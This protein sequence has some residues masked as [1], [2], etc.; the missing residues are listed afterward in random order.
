MS[1]SL[2]IPED[3][4]KTWVE[5]LGPRTDLRGAS[6]IAKEME[7]ALAKA[8][9]GYVVIGRHQLFTWGENLQGIAR[10]AP[11]GSP[12]QTV[13]DEIRSILSGREASPSAPAARPAGPPPPP[14]SRDWRPTPPPASL[15]APPPVTYA[16][17]A[18]PAGASGG[19][20]VRLVTETAQVVGNVLREARREL[21]V[22]SPWTLGLETLV[23]DLVRTAP[24]VK[25]TIV[26]RRPE[27]EDEA[28]HRALRDLQR[29]G[30]ELVM[31]PFLHTRMLVADGEVLLLGAAGL[32]KPG[33]NVARESAILT[34]D[35]AA[36]GA[37]REHVLRIFQEARSGRT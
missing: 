34:S 12:A 37:A 32:P 5:S 27:R 15:A 7:A 13:A 35:A 24:G 26:S 1:A 29:R 30:A 21:L 10:R 8:A 11:L 18:T 23:N 9:E 33:V 6:A 31:S 25:L 2:R 17:G 28:Y 14:S 19:A 16:R 3:M 36:V 20:G 4:I 22:V